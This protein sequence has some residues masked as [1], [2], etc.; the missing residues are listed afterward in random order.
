MDIERGCCCGSSQA[1][2]SR[3][4]GKP[5]PATIMR[6]RSRTCLER[7]RGE[8]LEIERRGAGEGEDDPQARRWFVEARRLNGVPDD[9]K[10]HGRIGDS[11]RPSGHSLQEPAGPATFPAELSSRCP[12]RDAPCLATGWP[13]IDASLGGFPLGGIHELF[14]VEWADPP[15]LEAAVRGGGRSPPGFVA[16]GDRRSPWI[17]PMGVAIRL[18]S[19][20]LREIGGGCTSASRLELPHRG[21]LWIGRAIRPEPDALCMPPDPR[22]PDASDS[23]RVDSALAARSFFLDPVQ[24]MPSGCSGGESRAESGRIWA[25]EQAIRHEA[26]AAI[27]ADGRGLTPA[28]SRRLQVATAGRGLP[29]LV[30]LLR[31]PREIASRSISAFRWRVDPC[32]WDRD[33]VDGGGLTRPCGTDDGWARGFEGGLHGRAGA[34]RLRLLRGRTSLPARVRGLIESDRGL[35]TRVEMDPW[36]HARFDRWRSAT[37]RHPSHRS[38]S[39]RAGDG[40]PF[41]A[42][43]VRSRRSCAG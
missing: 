25:I 9:R 29:S 12:P 20:A 24:T 2:G 30:L 39:D 33:A 23:S 43:T 14:G 11:A 37:D 31:E 34:W 13:E 3:S 15:P 17:P 18:A 5:Q 16:R 21:V 1:A 22:A 28:E 4:E 6:V 10:E 40:R 38:A 8:I 36:T 42:A 26:F 27:I 41:G 7:L 35:V 19:L 32:P